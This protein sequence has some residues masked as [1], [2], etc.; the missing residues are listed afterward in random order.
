MYL[1][2]CSVNDYVRYAPMYIIQVDLRPRR[3]MS[4]VSE[5]RSQYDFVE[6]IDNVP[7]KLRW[8]RYSNGLLQR[9]VA[10]AIGITPAMYKLLENGSKPLAQKEIVDKLAEF[11]GVRA[12]ELLDGYGRFCYYGQARAVRAYRERLGLGRKPF[13][14]Y[15]GIPLASL[16]EWE[17]GKKTV[18]Y[19]SWEKYFAGLA[20]E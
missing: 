7:D 18:S 14:K 17:D 19:K 2:C 9:Q 16:R 10:E 3:K 15:T 6:E 12:E 13:S 20:R 1:M 4:E 8:L 11:Y 5:L